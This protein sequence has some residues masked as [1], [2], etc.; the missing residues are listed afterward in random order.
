MKFL[1]S[2]HAT[3]FDTHHPCPYRYLASSPSQAVAWHTAQRITR[4]CSWAVMSSL[5]QQSCILARSNMHI[6]AWLPAVSLTAYTVNVLHQILQASVYR[7]TSGHHQCCT[8]PTNQ[9]LRNDIMMIMSFL[10]SCRNKKE[11]S[12]SIYTFRKVRTIRGSLEGLALMIWKSRMVLATPGPLLTPPPSGRRSTLGPRWVIGGS[13]IFGGH[14]WV[15]A[16]N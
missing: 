12:S 5:F 8:S 10:C 1:Y 9:R 4:T 6:R 11:E 14:P 15:P 3:L 2:H 13:P 7:D 16:E